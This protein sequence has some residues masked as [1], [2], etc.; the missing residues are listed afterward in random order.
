MWKVWWSQSGVAETQAGASGC[1]D[2]VFIHKYWMNWIYSVNAMIFVKKVIWWLLMSLNGVKNHRTSVGIPS[3]GSAVPPRTPWRMQC[4]ACWEDWFVSEC[5]KRLLP[6]FAVCNWC[7]QNVAPVWVNSADCC[8]CQ[9]WM[10]QMIWHIVE[11][12][13]LLECAF[14]LIDVTDISDELQLTS[15]RPGLA[16]LW[17][18]ERFP[19][20]TAFTAV[21][22]CF[23]SLPDQHH[24]DI[25]KNMS[26]CAFMYMNYWCYQLYCQETFSHK[27]GAVRSVDWIFIIGAQTWWWLGKTFYS[28]LFKQKVVAAPVIFFLIAFLK[29]VFIINVI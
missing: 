14:M 3:W 16:S 18:V 15:T 21:P 20:H 1:I 27:M 12:N 19:W 11:N 24:K 28:L 13:Q 8:A 10:H 5:L 2:I 23:I 25:I 29:E 7:R 17:Q 6:S 26:I 9:F 4:P 22:I